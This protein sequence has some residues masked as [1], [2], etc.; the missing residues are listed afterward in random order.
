MNSSSVI[1]ILLNFYW[2]RRVFISLKRTLKR[3]RTCFP[4]GI[5]LDYNLVSR[6]GVFRVYVCVIV[7]KL[8]IK[9][10]LFTEIIDVPTKCITT[11]EKVDILANVIFIDFEGRSDGESIRKILSQIRPRQLV[12]VMARVI[13]QYR[14]YNNERWPI[15]LVA[16]L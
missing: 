2:L 13:I 9:W 5:V 7:C 1:S 11:E 6:R 12:C 4:L 8:N 14:F 15:Y 16:R 3:K 10:C